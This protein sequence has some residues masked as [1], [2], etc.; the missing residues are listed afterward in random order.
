MFQTFLAAQRD[1]A[2]LWVPVLLGL[3]I[4]LYFSLE[5][6][7]H[8]MAGAGVFGL[9]LAALLL[10]ALKTRRMDWPVLGLA[11]LTLLA[12][13][14]SVAQLRT[15]MVDAPILTKALSAK[16][17]EGTIISLDDLDAGKGTRVILEKLVIEDLSP[18]QT[19]HAVRISIR[20]DEGL[21]PGQRIRVL[22]GLNP[23]SPPVA[24]GG[25]DFQRHAYFLRLGAFGFAYTAPEILETTSS[26]H[27]ERFRQSGARKVEA[28]VP[29]PEAS[30]VSALLL[31]E[32]A[33][34]PEETWQDIR[35]AGLAHVISISGLH[36]SMIAMGIFF[37]VRFI[38]ALFP[39]VALYHPI[40]KYAALIAM[41]G[42]IAYAVMVGLS[43]PT[44]RSVMMTGLILGAV[45]LDRS[46]FSLRLVALSAFLILLMTPEA[47]TG[48]SFQMSFAA[49]AC[50][51]FFYDETRNFWSNQNKKGGWF[52]KI[53]LILLGTCVTSVIATVATAPFTLYHF[54]Q[55]PIY[56]VV[57]NVLAFPVIA[58]VIMPAAIFSYLLMPF[59]LDPL[60]LWVMGKGVSVMLWIS[61]EIAAWQY[62]SLD[63]VAWPLAA[64]I[65]FVIAS[66][67]VMVIRGPV[68]W[69]GL[70]PFIA[71]LAFALLH[72]PP[73][74]LV[75]SSGKLAMIMA[76]NK[77]AWLSNRRSDKFTA[78][79]WIRAAGVDPEMIVTWPKEGV[80]GGQLAGLSCDV[81]GCIAT[82][83]GVNMGFSFAARTVLED[84]GHV[85]IIFAQDPVD[86]GLCL[87]SMVIDRWDLKD[88]GTYAIWI[89]KHSLDIKTVSET[90]GQRPWTLA[91]S[92]R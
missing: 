50:L 20:K 90:R 88:N 27:L 45:M 35:A 28:V 32:R 29:H 73:D 33:A 80:L 70:L 37:V 76:D 19:P 62:A 43:V 38:M 17:V 9:S 46:P 21:K 6:E 77:T 49:V 75:S 61:E 69:I 59:G 74:I 85:R 83:R 60:P 31:G 79:N 81:H 92:N 86:D 44:L 57:G 10:V 65:C 40:K 68:R 7:P 34:I 58:F 2:I 16:M 13:G 42:A 41:I 66:L 23:P 4:A 56:S 39:R 22:A 18:A 78:E 14:W 3:G 82:V 53:Y 24:P 54:Q 25:F 5:F 30:I 11:A 15:A 64:L 67:W 47:I 63:L 55:F 84:C 26:G 12:M 72:R 1:N 8:W 51:I 71:G 89:D 36:I 87:E 52:R 91:G 48:P